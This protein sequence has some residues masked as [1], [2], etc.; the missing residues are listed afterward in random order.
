MDLTPTIEQ[1]KE[2]VYKL[3]KIINDLE[4][5]QLLN[6]AVENAHKLKSNETDNSSSKRNTLGQ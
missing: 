6:R 5:Q 1:L 3:T 4:Y 2:Q